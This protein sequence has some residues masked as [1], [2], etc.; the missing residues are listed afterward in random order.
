MLTPDGVKQRIGRDD[1]VR[2]QQQHGQKRPLSRTAEFD[3]APV[4]RDLE[5]PE[6][7]ELQ[8]SFTL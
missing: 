5:R 4:V 3:K 7:P 6:N 8:H 2:P 1:L